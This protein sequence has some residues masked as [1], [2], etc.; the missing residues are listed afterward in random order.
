MSVDNLIERVEAAIRDHFAGMR[1]AADPLPLIRRVVAE[2]ER[3]PPIGPEPGNGNYYFLEANDEPEAAPG[4]RFF[5]VHRRYWHEHHYLA[6]H[7]DEE[8]FLPADF[9]EVSEATFESASPTARRDLLAAG[10]VELAAAAPSAGWYAD[11]G[12]AFTCG[13]VTLDCTVTCDTAAWRERLEAEEWIGGEY[14]DLDGFL[15]VARA[16]AEPLGGT[17]VLVDRFEGSGV[18][19][20][21]LALM[22]RALEATLPPYPNGEVDDDERD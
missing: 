11:V 6:T 5:V 1:P 19:S 13:G 22:D 14:E 8:V 16:W 15:A 7:F 3:E 4:T 10:F 2:I 12:L 20:A 21:H 17:L 18:N 9:D